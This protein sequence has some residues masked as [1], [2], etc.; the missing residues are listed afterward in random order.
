MSIEKGRSERNTGGLLSK[1]VMESM[2]V[3]QNDGTYHVSLPKG[4]V[5]DLGLQKGDRVLITGPEGERT[6]QLR[7]SGAVLADD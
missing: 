5:E 6:L 2:I 1:N 3:Q 4:A 7:P